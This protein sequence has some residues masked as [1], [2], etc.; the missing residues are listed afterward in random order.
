MESAWGSTLGKQYTRDH[1]PT[2]SI[3]MEPRCHGRRRFWN[4]R[5]ARLSSLTKEAAPIDLSLM[6]T[7]REL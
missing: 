6:S 4:L 7:L 2:V 3:S 5:S 1:N